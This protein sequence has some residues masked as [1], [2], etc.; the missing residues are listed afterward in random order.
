MKA[1]GNAAT[2]PG[3]SRTGIPLPTV[4]LSR[5]GADIVSRVAAQRAFVSPVVMHSTA[6]FTRDQLVRAGYQIEGERPKKRKRIYVPTDRDR[7]IKRLYEEEGLTLVQIGERHGLSHAGVSYALDRMQVAKVAR[8][9]RSANLDNVTDDEL[10]RMYR[11]EGLSC[12]VIAQQLGAPR[13][14]VSARIRATGV[15]IRG[16]QYDA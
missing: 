12:R 10:L 15:P 4:P 6:E 16:R 8:P 7:D 13:R 3:G 14:V 5:P 1:Y 11:D 9:G 2:I